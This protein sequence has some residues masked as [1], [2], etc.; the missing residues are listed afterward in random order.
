MSNATLSVY[1]SPW[2]RYPQYL[3]YATRLQ[4][5]W[6]RIH[7]P[8]AGDISQFQR[9]S[10][11]SKIMLR[12]WDFD[13]SDGD[14]KRELYAD[15]KAAARKL[16]EHWGD[17][18]AELERQLLEQGLPYDKSK[19]YFGAWNEP[20][21]AYIPQIVE[22]TLEA[23]RFAELFG[24]RLGV[25]CASVG[26]FGKPTEPAPNW[27]NFKPLEKPINEGG[28]ILIVHEYWQ[29]EGPAGVWTD[30]KGNQRSDAGNLAW[31]HRSIPLNVPILIG[32]SG[33]NGYIYGRMS[34]EDDCGWQRMM[35]ADTYAAQVRQYIEGCD[36][37]VQGVCLYM[38][39]YHSDQWASF[40]TLPAHDQLIA[41]S[42]ATPQAPSPFTKQI[43]VHLPV[44]E[45]GGGSVPAP[46]PQGVIDPQVLE[47]ILQIESGGRALGADGRPIIR[48]EPH[49]FKGQLGND[50]LFAQH[51]RYGNP[52]WTQRAMNDGSG[53]KS[54]EEGG[55]PRQWEA[56]EL[57]ASL[58]YEAAAQSISMGAP[59]IMGFNHASI[60]YPSA[61][62]MLEAFGNANV[63]VIAFINFI[64]GRQALVSAVR[65]KDWRE[66][67]R[68][69]NGAGNVDYY[70]SLLQ[71]AYDRI[72]G[73]T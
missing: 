53:W 30:A 54:I 20:D 16:L 49:I 55:Q 11:N 15:P 69:Y 47:A 59:Q 52:V 57:A 62:A 38:T 68:I 29:K 60:G 17:K 43:N 73:S 72:K 66:V 9:V 58:D 14:R 21:P 3:D 4:P 40:D 51:F 24:M 71:G 61:T 33:A 45:N 7:Q 65:N 18:A 46:L 25:V 32:E 39:D 27:N 31:R 44:V 63:Q 2:H 34:G 41:V 36:K 23:M 1:A 35:S 50:V 70:A 26:N 6:I 67:A 28:H 64:L 42:G 37:R 22:G 5:A 19:W 12:Q 56:F 8:Q 10:P 48:F 13:D